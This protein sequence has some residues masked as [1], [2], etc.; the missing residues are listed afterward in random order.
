M[1]TKYFV[2]HNVLKTFWTTY[3]GLDLVQAFVI[4]CMTEEKMCIFLKHNSFCA[5]LTRPL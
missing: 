2:M 4:L 1:G 3:F 5:C